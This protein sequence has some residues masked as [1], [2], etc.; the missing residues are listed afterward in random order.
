M[1]HRWLFGAM[2][3]Q[4]VRAGAFMKAQKRNNNVRGYIVLTSCIALQVEASLMR[5]L[6][7]SG[8]ERHV[9]MLYE[10]VR[11]AVLFSLT[12]RRTLSI[13]R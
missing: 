3:E 6:I 9:R 4:R 2:T 11:V 8:A 13:I 10:F 7:I 5:S 1:E 12:M